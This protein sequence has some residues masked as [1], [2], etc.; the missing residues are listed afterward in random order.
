MLFSVVFRIPLNQN[1]RHNNHNRNTHCNNRNDHNLN[2][3]HCN[4]ICDPN[5]KLKPWYSIPFYYWL[6]TLYI[7]G[8]YRWNCLISW[9]M[10]KCSIQNC[11]VWNIGYV[12]LFLL[13]SMLSSFQHLCGVILAL[14]E[15][16]TC[17]FYFYYFCG[18]NIFQWLSFTSKG[19][20]G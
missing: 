19:W 8:G 20:D 11:K 9:F 1:S 10:W 5:H 2:T 15:A 18:C 14:N 13:S 7:C 4:H 3:C 16:G 12:V 17:W 6:E